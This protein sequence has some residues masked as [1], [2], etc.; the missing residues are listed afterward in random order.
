MDT[1]TA[2]QLVL[3]PSLLEMEIA[4]GNFKCYKFQGTDHI[5]AELIKA[6]GEII[7]SEV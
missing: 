2:E 7:C 1:H 4:I 5:L 3:E 6:R